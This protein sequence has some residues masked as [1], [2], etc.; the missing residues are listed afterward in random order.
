MG[1]VLLCVL[2]SLAAVAQLEEDND[3]VSRSPRRRDGVLRQGVDALG[4]LFKRGGVSSFVGEA[5]KDDI[6][7]RAAKVVP[8][9]LSGVFSNVAK[10]LKKAGTKLIKTVSKAVQEMTEGVIDERIKKFLAKG[11]VTNE[12]VKGFFDKFLTSK[13]SIVDLFKLL[14]EWKFGPDDLFKIFT[15]VRVTLDFPI[16]KKIRASKPLMKGLGEMLKTAVNKTLRLSK[17]EVKRVSQVVNVTDIIDWPKRL[18]IWNSALQNISR[19][20]VDPDEGNSVAF[21]FIDAIGGAFLEAKLFEP[22]IDLLLGQAPDYQAWEDTRG[23]IAF[24]PEVTEKV[25]SLSTDQEVL[26]VLG[27]LAKKTLPQEPDFVDS[28]V[29]AFEFEAKISTKDRPVVLGTIIAR[30]YEAIRNRNQL[31]SLLSEFE[32]SEFVI[33]RHRARYR[34]W[35]NAYLNLALFFNNSVPGLADYYYKLELPRGTSG[36]RCR[37]SQEANP[38]AMSVCREPRPPQDWVPVVIVFGL[39]IVAT[40]AAGVLALV[41]KSGSTFHYILLACL[42]VACVFRL[43]FFASFA[44]PVGEVYD[45]AVQLASMSLEAQAA[46]ERIGAV[47]F[48]AI[49]SIFC[50]VLVKANVETLYPEKK[51]LFVVLSWIGAI[52]MALIALYAI[53]M[54]IVWNKSIFNEHVLDLSRPLLSLASAVFASGLAIGF[55]F[56]WASVRKDELLAPA[57]KR[58]LLFLASSSVL[59]VLFLLAFVFCV[60]YTFLSV[61]G[62]SWAYVYT[63]VAAESAL[64]LAIVLYCFLAITAKRMPTARQRESSSLADSSSSRDQSAVPLLYSDY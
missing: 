47:A 6:T 3:G 43:T 17:K 11:G 36:M 21:K 35:R 30:K 5:F 15:W 13:I 39:L 23:P 42:L 46:V 38:F 64:G 8:R 45:I 18:L 28:L 52:F 1:R 34:R 12:M 31:F 9:S 58:T 29:E 26:K 57:R 62:W 19:G 25:L 27:L 37:A 49:C 53:I 61:A 10:E 2:F 44:V 50:F 32:A 33:Q 14:E 59:A 48:A 7:K 60:L 24:T 63:T 22:L 20:V 4:A 40:V 16:V 54:V 56:T 51:R 41:W 55:V